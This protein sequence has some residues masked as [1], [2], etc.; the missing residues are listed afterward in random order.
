MIESEFLIEH[1]AFFLP[2]VIMYAELHFRFKW[3]DSRYF[4]KEPEILSDLPIR[5]EP[6]NNIPILLIIKDAHIYPIN[7]NKVNIKTYYN[8]FIFRLINS[9]GMV[10]VA[11][12]KYKHSTLWNN[13]V[14]V[15]VDIFIFYCFNCSIY[16]R[17]SRIVK[18]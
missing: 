4:R 8:S 16:C 18:S 6:G 10:K 5:I 15:A 7:L 3:S 1:F 12:E 14:G 17:G 11:W 9:N 2:M 13:I